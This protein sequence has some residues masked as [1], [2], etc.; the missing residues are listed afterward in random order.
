[1]R[2]RA[3]EGATQTVEGFRLQVYSATNK[4]SA[5]EFR[6]QVQSWLQRTRD[7][8]PDGLFASNEAPVVIQYSQPYYRVR[9]GAFTT[10][11]EAQEALDFVRTQYSD[12]FIARST[13]TITR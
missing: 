12:A 4:Q 3:D 9:I 11:E 1:M 8:A 7:D 10:R 6:A 5:E 2:L 13:V